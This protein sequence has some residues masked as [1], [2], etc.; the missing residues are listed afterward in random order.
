MT[1]TTAHMGKALSLY[2]RGPLITI[3]ISHTSEGAYALDL[4]IEGAEEGAERLPSGSRGIL[5]IR[6]RLSKPCSFTAPPSSRNNQQEWLIS[7]DRCPDLETAS[8][9]RHGP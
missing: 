6:Q 9:C 2:V 1:N 3:V 7:G 4:T 5:M 8:H